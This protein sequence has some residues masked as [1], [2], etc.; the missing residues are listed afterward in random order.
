MLVPAEAC[1]FTLADLQQRVERSR[2]GLRVQHGVSRADVMPLGYE[3]GAIHIT[4]SPYPLPALARPR[5]A[6]PRRCAKMAPD[7]LR[8]EAGAARAE[9]RDPPRSLGNGD[10]EPGSM[11]AAGQVPS[12]A[13]FHLASPQ[14]AGPR[15]ARGGKRPR[16]CSS[17]SRAVALAVPAPWHLSLPCL[18]SPW[19]FNWI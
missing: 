4:V 10:A 11:A 13:A 7:R 18:A 12:L 6:A 14:P 1:C 2:A 15:R 17:C 5:T 3:Q 9:L 19:S 16:C 8:A